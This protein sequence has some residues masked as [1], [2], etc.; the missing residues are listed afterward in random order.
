MYVDLL[1]DDCDGTS[2]VGFHYYNVSVVGYFSKGSLLLPRNVG[3]SVMWCVRNEIV[4]LVTS[5]I[6][7]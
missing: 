3:S 6:D 7:K 4:V 2:F 5:V 1:V